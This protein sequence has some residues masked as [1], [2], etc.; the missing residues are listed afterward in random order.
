MAIDSN[1]NK[2]LLVIGLQ[3]ASKDAIA[4]GLPMCEDL[5]DL[6]M[7]MADDE[8]NIEATF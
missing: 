1:L 5:K 6:F 4:K 8:A 3:D 2:V 7:D